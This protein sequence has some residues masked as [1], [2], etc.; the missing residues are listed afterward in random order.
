[1]PRLAIRIDHELN[2]PTNH[3]RPNFAPA[4][5]VYEPAPT[6]PRLST[7]GR[8]TAA[9]PSESIS[10]RRIPLSFSNRPAA[11]DLIDDCPRKLAGGRKVTA[12]KPVQARFHKTNS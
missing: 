10:S 6:Q 5:M 3:M 9:P 2:L 11:G 8:D 7:N 4:R 1:M 12:A